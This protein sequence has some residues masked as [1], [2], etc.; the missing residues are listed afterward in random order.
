MSL[1]PHVV[2]VKTLYRQ[3]LKNTFNWYGFDYSAYVIQANELR[4]KFEKYRHVKDHGEAET[5]IKEAEALLEALRH[6]DPYRR[7]CRVLCVHPR[8]HGNRSLILMFLSFS[9][10]LSAAPVV[11][12]SSVTSPSPVI[13]LFL[14][15]SILTITTILTRSSSKCGTFTCIDFFFVLSPCLLFA[16]LPRPSLHSQRHTPR[17]HKSIYI[18][19]S[20][21]V[22]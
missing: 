4:E 9:P 7:T 18:S 11:V 1:T 13:S 3:L 5:L 15:L 2:R 12:C 8:L 17:N 16:V 19:R 6:P 21:I 22:S 10:Q 20:L 14:V